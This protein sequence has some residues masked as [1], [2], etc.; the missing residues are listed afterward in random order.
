[1]FG[2]SLQTFRR[3]IFLSFGFA[4]SGSE[5]GISDGGSVSGQSHRS[6]Y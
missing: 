6:T 1:M 2:M 5:A 4:G 3:P